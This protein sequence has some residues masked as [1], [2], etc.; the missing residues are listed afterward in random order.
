MGQSVPLSPNSPHPTAAYPPYTPSSHAITFPRFLCPA[1]R[2]QDPPKSTPHPHPA[3]IPALSPPCQP[4]VPS[5]TCGVGTRL[6][7]A[8]C[9][10]PGPAE[11]VYKGPGRNFWKVGKTLSKMLGRE[12]KGRIRPRSLSACRQW[13]GMPAPRMKGGRDGWGDAP[14]LLLLC[15][16]LPLPVPSLSP[17]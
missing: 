4:G 7:S 2:L 5:L 1:R 8:P 13:Q 17:A 9:A 10:P 16:E 6:C 3:A 12:R 15:L 14:S 11:G